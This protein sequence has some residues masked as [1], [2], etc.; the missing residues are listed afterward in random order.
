ML[1]RALE[2]C[3]LRFTLYPDN[4]ELPDDAPAHVLATQ[5][6]PRR[7]LRASRIIAPRKDAVLLH[8][9]RTDLNDALTLLPSLSFT[10]LV[11]S[12]IT[13]EREGCCSKPCLGGFVCM[14]CC[15]NEAF[16]HAGSVTQP[17]GQPGGAGKLPK[18]QV[19]GRAKVP[20]GGGGK[21][22]DKPL[23]T[24]THSCVFPTRAEPDFKRTCVLRWR[25]PCAKVSPPRSR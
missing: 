21:A 11:P 15:A 7:Q 4:D 2:G 13:M 20:I 23:T 22:R 6:A 18:T 14:D 19:I 16:I 25:G 5:V 10:V 3:F 24:I 12:V 1:R 17:D 9:P 8:G